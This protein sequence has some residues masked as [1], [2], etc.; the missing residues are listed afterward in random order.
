MNSSIKDDEDLEICV[1]P[2][3][4]HCSM[5]NASDVKSGDYF[6]FSDHEVILI[7]SVRKG[8]SG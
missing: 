3:G 8:K 4:P 5:V 7:D 6:V 1:E 2:V